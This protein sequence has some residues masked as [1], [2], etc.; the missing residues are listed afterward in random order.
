ML[1]KGMPSKGSRALRN[2]CAR[3]YDA[4]MEQVRH[5]FHFHGALS[6]LIPGEDGAIDLYVHSIAEGLRLLSAQIP[7]FG[8]TLKS[9]SW[10]IARGG[11]F[12]LE[13]PEEILLSLGHSPQELHFVPAVAGAKSGGIGKAILGGVIMAV[14]LVGA[15][16]SGGATLA[17]PGL[18]F[19]STMGAGLA[20]SIAG[21][22]PWGSMLA[23][24]G[25]LTLS[26]LAQMM[27]PQSKVNYNNHESADQRNSSIYQGPTNTVEQGHP[28]PLVYGRVRVGSVV[29]A[30]A[31]Y[32][33]RVL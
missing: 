28:V 22:F 31:L 11:L 15:Y 20:S 1:V 18:S 17:G 32:T 27:T 5:T 2:L 7:S 3:G 29:A 19:S 23:L 12:E 26:G 30:T 4:G 21:G 25:M 16:F 14:A 24:G 33:E 13:S 6:G 10:H 9:G 8:D